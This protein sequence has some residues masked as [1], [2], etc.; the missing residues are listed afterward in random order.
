MSDQFKFK[1]YTWVEWAMKLILV[2]A[3]TLIW[4]I[5]QDLQRQSMQLSN[6][7]LIQAGQAA[8]IDKLEAQLESVRREYVTRLEMLELVKRV[9]QQLQIITLQ[10]KLDK[11]RR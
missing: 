10:S 6:Q 11:G 9:E 2:A 4:Q 7:A 5:Y 1:V 3:F 8:R